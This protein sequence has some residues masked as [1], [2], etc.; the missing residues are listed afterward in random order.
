MEYFC[1][2]SIFNSMLL[3]QAKGEVIHPDGV[4]SP[5][6]RVWPLHHGNLN[7]HGIFF[8]DL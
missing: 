6:S 2:F 4:W 8:V 5:V 1:E 3:E 7:G